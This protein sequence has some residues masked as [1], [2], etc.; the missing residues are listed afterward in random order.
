[1]HNTLKNNLMK[2]L[3]KYFLLACMLLAAWIT[4]DWFW[5]VQTSLREFNPEVVAA[6]DT[7]MWKAYYAREPVKMFF[8]MTGLL[9]NQFHA[10][11]WRSNII[12]YQAGKAAFV[13]KKGSSREDYEKALPYL[14]KYYTQVNRL[15]KEKFDI[16][17]CAETELE[18]WIVHR[19]KR[20]YSYKDLE[21]ALQKNAAAIY[22]M[23]DSSFRN[24]AFYR[25]K[26]MQLRDAKD[27]Q[28]TL[29]STDWQ[30]IESD[31][32][33]SWNELQNAVSH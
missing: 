22:A 8:Q 2:R 25:T 10:P 28:H 20:K 17:Q 21:K 30:S 4:A 19:N 6:C 32:K 29:T 3:F 18:W 23:P 16:K 14:E 24:Y 26:A 12:A 7:K 15:S 33:R 5:P 1:M 27:V 11:F 31:L 13:F 9:R